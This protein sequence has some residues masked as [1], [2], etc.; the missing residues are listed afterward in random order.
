MLQ[1]SR[2]GKVSKLG[3]IQGHAKVFHLLKACYFLNQGRQAIIKARHLWFCTIL[4]YSF[5][6]KS[7]SPKRYAK[8][9][10]IIRMICRKLE[11]YLFLEWLRSFSALNIH[12]V[13]YNN[14]SAPERLKDFQ[15]LTEWWNPPNKRI[16]RSSSDYGTAMESKIY[17]FLLLLLKILHICS[18]T[19][20][21]IFYMYYA[22]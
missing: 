9:I 18:C 8:L 4:D 17:Y 1:A 7:S 16:S 19:P 13:H 12:D 20:N 21:I 5:V 6:W 14:R 11:K 22:T 15:G 10:T 3:S 2:P